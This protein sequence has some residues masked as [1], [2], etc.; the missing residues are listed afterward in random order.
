MWFQLFSD[1]N[2]PTIS[3]NDIEQAYCQAS[4]FQHKEAPNADKPRLSYCCAIVLFFNNT[5]QLINDRLE[6]QFEIIKHVNMRRPNK[7][8]EDIGK[9]SMEVLIVDQT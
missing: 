8:I 7:Y 3:L 4:K 6:G 9:C 1:G 2:V 5:I